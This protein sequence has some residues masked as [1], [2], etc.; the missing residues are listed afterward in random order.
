MVLS[1]GENVTTSFEFAKDGLVGY[2]TRWLILFVA[3]C[4]PIVNFIT[5]GYL[6]KIYRGVD[7]AP[8]LEGYLEM[9]IDGLKL[10]IIEIVYIIVPLM[11]IVASTAFME[12]ET[13]VET[14]DVSGMT[15]TTG[16]TIMP[17]S[18]PT[19]VG[20][21][22]ILIG[23]LLAVIF[24]LVATIAGIRFAKTGEFGEGFNFGA[25]FETINEIGWGHYIL[26]SIV[27]IIVVCIIAVVL[28]LIPYIGELLVMII[29]PLLILWQGKFFENLYSC[30]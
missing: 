25:I 4:I 24:S 23:A 1:I 22:L 29:V 28:S 9:F 18:E 16:A 8:E 26:A 6:V 7:A 2:W 17:A 10:L 20:L 12:T 19:G 5:F 14:I 11:L 27:F 15:I 3:G 13:V 21:A 30:A